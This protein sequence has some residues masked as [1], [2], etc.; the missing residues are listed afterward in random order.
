MDS[1]SDDD[2]SEAGQGPL[3]HLPDVRETVPRASASDL[4]SL[5]GGGEDAS[6]LAIACP[7]AKAD[8]PESRVFGKRTVSLV[9]SAVEVEQATEEATQ[10][11][12]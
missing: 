3:D 11:S 6:G 5:G 9:G 2:E 8:A 12:L 7:G 4:A 1:L 10:R